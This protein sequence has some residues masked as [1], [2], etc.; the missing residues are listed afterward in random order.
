MTLFGEDN[1]EIAVKTENAHTL[2]PIKLPSH[3]RTY[4]RKT[5]MQ[6][7]VYKCHSLSLGVVSSLEIII[8]PALGRNDKLHYGATG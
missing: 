3:R 8:P 2:P 6:K 1:L 5:K 4:L 7:C